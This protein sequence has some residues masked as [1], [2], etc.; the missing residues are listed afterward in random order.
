MAG[1]L[2]CFRPQ[3]T[4]IFFRNR[5]H[6]FVN[7]FLHALAAVGFGGEEIAFR[8]GS[9]AVYGVELAG[10]APAVAEAGQDFQRVAKQ[11]VNFFIRA[12]SQK[13]VGLLG[14]LGKGDVP[15]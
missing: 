12:I 1:S 14:I 5:R 8:I 3:H 4:L 11:D 15:D 7:E 13:N 10:L 9:D 2:A 6:A